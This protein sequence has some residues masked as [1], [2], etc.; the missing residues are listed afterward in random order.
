MYCRLIMFRLQIKRLVGMIPLILLE[1][2]LFALIVAGAGIYAVKAVYGDKAISEIR[3]GVVADSEDSLIKMLVK[4]IQSM[5]S[6]KDTVSMEFMPEQEARMQVEEGKIYGAV[7]IPEGMVEGILSGKNIP[8]S[9]LLG[10]GY[11]Q[12]ETE[13]F[14]QLARAGGKLLTTAQAG[15]YAAD[16]LCME[17]GMSNRIQ[18]T[19]DY[20]NEVYLEYALGRGSVFQKEEVD[21]VK[22]TGI[23]DYYGISLLLAFISL[24]G[25]TFGKCIYIKTGERER[26]LAARGIS[27]KEQYLI[28]AGAFSIVLAL[29][30]MMVSLPVCFFLIHYTDSS[31]QAAA[32]WIFL[33]FVWLVLG[34]FLRML[35]Q[36]T[37]NSAGGIGICFILILAGM[38]VSGVFLPSSFLPIWME[39]AGNCFFYKGWMEAITV[40]LQGRVHSGIMVKL[41]IQFILFLMAGVFIA[42]IKNI[43]VWR[44]TF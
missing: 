44:K 16:T 36:L 8:A 38:A 20:L 30:G 41:L 24:A 31:F 3:I 26:M 27:V 11:S 35:L 32:V 6:M 7:V 33:A 5:D 37:G 4:L 43:V 25:L 10:N 2:L 40:I 22:G 42:E 23:T 13:V 28:E 17:N 1:T 19:E 29:F 39:K 21:A 14:S 18:Q 9:I 34:S 12:A 15:I